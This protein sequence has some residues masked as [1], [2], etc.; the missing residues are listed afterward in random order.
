MVDITDGKDVLSDRVHG[1]ILGAFTGDALGTYLEFET[2]LI[3]QD[4]VQNAMNMVGG[5]PF[6]LAPGQVTDDSEM[7]MMQLNGLVDGNGTLNTF[8]LCKFYADWYHSDPFDI[9]ITTRRGLCY[10]S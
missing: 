8:A 1:C 4:D 9:G 5:G 3:S 2:G 7:A 10:C 6:K